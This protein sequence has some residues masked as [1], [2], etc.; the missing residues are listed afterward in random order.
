M[1]FD[2][3]VDD[4]QNNTPA[5]SPL[6][7]PAPVSV[8]FDD[9]K[10]EEPSQN[11]DSLVDD[12]ENKY[13]TPGQQALTV[14]ENFAK[15]LLPGA[16]TYAEQ[17]LS[18][19]GIPG[20]SNEDILAR[21]AANPIE[22][23]GAEIGGNVALM[24]A[25]P[26]MEF[27]KLGQIGSKAINA[28]IQMGGISAG[29]EISKSLLGQGDPTPT[30][31]ANIAENGALGL[32]SGGI[33]GKVEQTGLK[34]LENAKLGT[35]LNSFLAGMGHAATIPGEDIV[36]LEKSALLGSEKSNLSDTAFRLGQTVYKNMGGGAAALVGKHFGGQFG[37]LGGLGIEKAIEKIVAPYTSRIS[38][39]YIAPTILKVAQHGYT[40]GLAEALDHAT[41]LAKG[42]KKIS[43][44]IE[45]LFQSGGGKAIEIINSERDR[46]NLKEFVERGGVDKQAQDAAQ[47]TTPDIPGYAEG[48]K[49]KSIPPLEQSSAISK[50]WPEQNIMLNTAK[51]RVSKFLNS[52]R[53]IP[54]Q[55][56]LPYDLEHKSP[57]KEH[58]YNQILDLANQPLS[59]LNKIKDGSLSVAHAGAF[60]SMYPELHQE[61]SKKM[62]KK[63]MEKGM[64]EN[65][66]PPYHMRQAMSL[67]LGSNLE[68]TLM[69]ANI[70]AAQNTF[71]ARKAQ[72]SQGNARPNSKAQ[73]SKIGQSAQTP[74]QARQARQS[75]L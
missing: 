37:A 34:A 24:V 2:S 25:L 61:L 8:K 30:V 7:A 48:G 52:V 33:F 26:E 51:G 22:A 44:G 66:R 10:E 69:P 74:D 58:E 5:P 62:T 53:P 47:T 4:N 19:F 1:D 64:K 11:F 75:K 3:L 6:P 40:E 65:K 67:F 31:A 23:G 68:S 16:A 50:L 71:V 21:K 43:N 60:R 54:N 27:A 15:G 38:Q 42:A 12:S 57:Q 32:V 36:S 55:N 35:K 49:V 56:K 46:N 14:G 73:L 63:I 39:K 29:D 17:K 59:I 41:K 20:I 45:N 13:S 70:Q 28:M 9:L 72:Q 18:D